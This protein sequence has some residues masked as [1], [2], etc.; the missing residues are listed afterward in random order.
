M[1][2]KLKLLF[3]AFLGQ[4][5]L[6]SGALAG[7]PTNGVDTTGLNAQDE[8]LMSSSG[9]SGNSNL[10]TIISILIQVVLGFLGI[11]FLVLTISAGF[12]WMSSQG[13]EKTV[14][15]AKESLKNSIIGL[16]I[17]IA[18]YTITYSVLKYLPFSSNGGGNNGA[19]VG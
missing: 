9:L 5:I 11:V 14:G 18:A 4:L 17:V 16:L 1:I 8:A 15:E 7:T 13:N 10:A 19:I 2:S 12:K 3:F 6:V